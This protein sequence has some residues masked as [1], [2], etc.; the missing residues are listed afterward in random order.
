MSSKTPT[1]QLIQVPELFSIVEQGVFRCASPTAAQVSCAVSATTRRL[2][3]CQIPYLQSL[4]LKTIIS[5]TPEHPIK[6]LLA[7]AKTNEVNFVRLP[8]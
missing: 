2:I 8:G 3:K 6:P 4:G 5:L 7:Y 1:A